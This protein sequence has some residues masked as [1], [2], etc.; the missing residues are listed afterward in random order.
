META[1]STS[2]NANVEELLGKLGGYFGTSQFW[3]SI[4]IVIGGI[5]LWQVI[6]RLKKKWREHNGGGMSTASH[7]IFDIIRFLFF[8]V[9]IIVLLQINGINVTALVTGIGVV[10]IIVGFALQDIL[11]DIIMGVHILT[12]KF[13]EVGDVIRYNGVEGV[14]I[15]FNIRTT[16]IKNVRYN[17]IMTICNRNI[18]EVEVLSDMFDLDIDLPYYVDAKLIHDTM[19]LCAKQISSLPTVSECLYKGTE[20]FNDSSITYR[21][22]Y[23]TPP[24]GRR[25]DVRRACISIVQKTLKE[26]GIPFPYNH[27]DVEIVGKDHQSLQTVSEDPQNTRRAKTYRNQEPAGEDLQIEKPAETD[28]QI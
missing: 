20:R 15:S 22:R 25:F 27:L 28:T 19:R 21:L 7:V 12:D 23:F 13:F 10:S 5:I 16:K 18:S 3:V 6:K 11:K 8:F 4:V 2:S 1:L 26:A 24:D 14:V 9:M 17:E